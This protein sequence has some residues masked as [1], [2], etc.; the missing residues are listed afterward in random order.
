M[1]LHVYH[2]LSVQEYKY[3]QLR[4]LTLPVTIL[5]TGRYQVRY[6]AISVNALNCHNDLGR[7][8]MT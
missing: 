2:L 5:Y 8:T 7:L 1:P 3:N 6:C 4:I